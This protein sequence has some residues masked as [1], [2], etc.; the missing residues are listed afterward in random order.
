MGNRDRST[1]RSD[2]GYGDELPEVAARCPSD[3]PLSK[4]SHIPQVDERKDYIIIIK[5][6]ADHYA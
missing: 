1:L 6:N 4:L 2:S 3:H 5:N